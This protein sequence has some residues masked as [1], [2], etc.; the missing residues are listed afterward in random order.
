MLH[1]K[2]NEVPKQASRE[3]KEVQ[4]QVGFF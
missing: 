3:S 1:G 2:P 4:K